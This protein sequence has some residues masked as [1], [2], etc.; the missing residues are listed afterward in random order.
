ME[1]TKGTLP[2]GFMYKEKLQTEF[3]MG[4]VKTAGELFDAEQE[5]GGI[6][7]ELG[8]NASLM[9]RQLV[10]IGEC[11][12]PF[13]LQQIRGLKPADFQALRIAQVKLNRV[14]ESPND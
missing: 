2:H 10:R 11:E 1:I 5:S 12:G 6:Q 14:E 9:A 7:N 13:T 8:F 3:E 4:E